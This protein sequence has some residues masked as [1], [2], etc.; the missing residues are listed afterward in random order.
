MFRSGVR[1]SDEGRCGG[2]ARVRGPLLRVGLMRVREGHL[3][4]ECPIYCGYLTVPYSPF[5]CRERTCPWDEVG[6][7]EGAALGS[8]GCCP[9]LRRRAVGWVRAL[10]ARDGW[11]PGAQALRRGWSWE[12][13][14]LRSRQ[15]ACG[16]L[17]P[18]SVSLCRRPWLGTPADAGEKPQC[19][20]RACVRVCVRARDVGPRL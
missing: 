10:P 13:L 5:S 2:S 11:F 1:H 7:G 14:A 12:T 15:A 20:G 4:Q 3:E 8:H 18:V 9:R 16:D 19:W 6:S 17:Q